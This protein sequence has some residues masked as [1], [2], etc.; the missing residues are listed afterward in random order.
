MPDFSIGNFSEALRRYST[1]KSVRLSIT[2]SQIHGVKVVL[3][4]QTSFDKGFDS[5]DRGRH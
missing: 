5:E 2:L 4:V 1:A 3:I